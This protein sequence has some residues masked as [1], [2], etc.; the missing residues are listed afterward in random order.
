MPEV[1]RGGPWP[2]GRRIVS[3]MAFSSRNVRFLAGAVFLTVVTVVTIA[4]VGRGRLLSTLDVPLGG[5]DS[6]IPAD[7]APEARALLAEC[8][9]LAGQEKIDCYQALL[10]LELGRVGVRPTMTTLDYLCKP[11]LRASVRE[12]FEKSGGA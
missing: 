7:S 8:G 4:V 9:D 1:R 5:R 12:S 2:R 10:S 3:S 11:E 6:G